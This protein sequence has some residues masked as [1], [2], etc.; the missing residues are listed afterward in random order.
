MAPDLSRL[1]RQIT[2]ALMALA[3]LAT[4]VA[5][6]ETR[7]VERSLGL[8][9][10]WVGLAIAISFFVQIPNDNRRVPSR[11]VLFV[12]LVLA[13]APFLIEK[14]LRSWF[15]TGYPLEV[16]MVFALRNM[17]LGLA[18]FGCWSLCQR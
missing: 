11:T 9:A 1:L 17:G 5:A 7:S 2:F 16:Q 10:I 18:A 14:M 4:E 3:A 6:E 8:A 12:L 13:A 15:A